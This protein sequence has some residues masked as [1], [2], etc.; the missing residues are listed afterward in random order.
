V[1]RSWP[2]VEVHA[3]DIADGT[4]FLTEQRRD[5]D[6]I[7]TNPPGSLVGPI[8]E[9]A[10]E[11]TKRRRGIVALLLRADID[12]AKDYLRLFG[13]CP[14]FAKRIALTKRIRWIRDSTG[15]PQHNHAWWL[16]DWRHQGPPRLAYYEHEET[17]APR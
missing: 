8:I 6:G 17:K 5:F 12:G 7:I 3:S 1:L 4:D 10:L 13:R 15:S 9:H 11:L 16:W 14:Q 2:G